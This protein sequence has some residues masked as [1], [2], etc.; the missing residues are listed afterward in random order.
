MSKQEK[1]KRGKSKYDGVRVGV[2]VGVNLVGTKAATSVITTI[3][4]F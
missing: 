2:D 4:D 1:V 3:D